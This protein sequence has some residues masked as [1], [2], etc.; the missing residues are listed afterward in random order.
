MAPRPQ[1]PSRRLPLLHGIRRRSRSRHLRRLE[2]LVRRV[3]DD[4]LLLRSASM[5]GRAADHFRSDS[6]ACPSREEQYLSSRYLAR[7]CGVRGL[8]GLL[9]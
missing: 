2:G 5:C 8:V 7:G 9:Y 1:T 6:A 4:V 3:H